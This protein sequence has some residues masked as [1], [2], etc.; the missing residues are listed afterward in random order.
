LKEN[1]N[2]EVLPI[3]KKKIIKARQ[4]ALK[5]LIEQ[6][7]E[8]Q[9][10]ELNKETEGDDTQ[11]KTDNKEDKEDDD[12]NDVDDEK[13][14]ADSSEEHKEKKK[15]EK[16]K[17]KAGGMEKRSR[18]YFRLQAKRLAENILFRVILWMSLL[19]LVSFA[20]YAI[21][22]A[23]ISS[24]LSYAVT[25][26]LSVVAFQFVIS[27]M[28]PH[29]PYL[30]LIDK[31]NLMIFGTVLLQAFFAVLSG[32]R[33]AW[34]SDDAK[35]ELDNNVFYI[36][37]SF[38]V[39]MHVAAYFYSQEKIKFELSK[40]GLSKNYIDVLNKLEGYPTNVENG[41]VEIM[42]FSRDRYKKKKD[43]LRSY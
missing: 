33:G 28:V 34:L 40:I 37:F 2:S 26:N 41:L 31:Y 3:L 17:H 19:G 15:K 36:M 20:I 42:S 21:D 4:K 8:K 39:L 9:L 29:V 10:E 35:L 25:M 27:S 22:P 6:E 13:S 43:H 1:R 12:D 23:D 32:A 18:M 11:D 38:F 16:K 30:T 24:R 5:K 14:D 7:G